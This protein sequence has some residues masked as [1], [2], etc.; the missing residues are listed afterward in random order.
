MDEQRG[1]H[2]LPSDQ[3]TPDPTPTDCPCQAPRSGRR[4]LD[5][6]ENVARA[7]P[8]TPTK[9]REDRVFTRKRD[10]ATRGEV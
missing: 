7:I 8:T 5:T 3:E 10:Q 1:A 2:S 4:I 6:P 9:R